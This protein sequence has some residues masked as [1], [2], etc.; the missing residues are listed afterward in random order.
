MASNPYTHD[1]LTTLVYWMADNQYDA[2]DLAHAVEKPHN[3]E[4][5]LAVACHERDNEGH[6]A[7]FNNEEQ[8]V[9]CADCNWQGDNINQP[10][11]AG[12]P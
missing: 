6:T 1:D 2:H 8:Y 7:N 9:E 12:H 11:G 10:R 5:E 3:Y 4:R